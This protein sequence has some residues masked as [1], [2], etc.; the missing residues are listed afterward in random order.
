MDLWFLHRAI[1]K[2]PI[3]S[4]IPGTGL[5]VTSLSLFFL[6]NSRESLGK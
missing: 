5:G 6:L 1:L 2:N 3:A 4:S